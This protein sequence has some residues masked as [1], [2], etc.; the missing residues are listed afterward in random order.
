MAWRRRTRGRH[1]RPARVKVVM[2]EAH[3]WPRVTRV[4]L[5]MEPHPLEIPR[6]PR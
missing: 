4:Q 2:D 5:P 6:R 1:G 3:G